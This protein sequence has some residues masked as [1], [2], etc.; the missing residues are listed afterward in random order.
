[1]NLRAG[2]QLPIYVFASLVAVICNAFLGEFVYGQGELDVV[3]TD[4]DRRSSAGLEATETEFLDRSHWQLDV[5]DWK[6]VEALTSGFRKYISDQR[7]S[8]LEVLGIHAR[9][10][11]ERSRYAR[12]WARLMIED[13][14]RVLAF[15]RA[16]DAAVRDLLKDKPLIDLTQLPVRSPNTPRLIPSDRLAVFV[17]T[18]CALCDEVLA[19]AFRVGRELAGV[20]IYVMELAEE[21]EVMLHAWA[22]QHGIPPIAVNSKRITI[23]IDD[24]LLKRVHPRAGEVPVV[25]RRRGDRLDPLDLW[26][27]P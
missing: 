17:S 8:P 19:H 21:H 11:E 10:D 9:S 14:E 2:S 12:R 23:N 27:L 18:D 24:G 6:R 13:A 15:Q 16:Y 25:M 20:D 22:R 3:L 26:S 4:I 7:I 1:M 5:N